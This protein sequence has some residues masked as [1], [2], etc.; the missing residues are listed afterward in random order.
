MIPML[1]ELSQ[2]RQGLVARCAVERDALA[3]AFAP[4]ARTLALADRALQALRWA[5]RTLSLVSVLRRLK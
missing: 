1:G 4:Y 2:R 5:L 3:Q